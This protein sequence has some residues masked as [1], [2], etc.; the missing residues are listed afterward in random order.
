M[1]G[2]AKAYRAPAVENLLLDQPCA[3]AAAQADRARFH[4][5]VRCG[6][7]IEATNDEHFPRDGGACGG[8]H[9]AFRTETDRVRD[10]TATRS[11]EE[12]GE[13][14][15]VASSF[16]IR[17]PREPNEARMS[18]HSRP[19]M[20]HRFAFGASKGDHCE[21]EGVFSFSC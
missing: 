21:G 16:I 18:R 17:V 7:R 4:V 8:G 9:N 6:V 19:T 1:M 15:L 20:T 10:S 2:I 3:E 11:A 13:L 14:V 12:G 5:G